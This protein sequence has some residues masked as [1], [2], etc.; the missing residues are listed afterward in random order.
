MR[1]YNK[2]GNGLQ[3][4][5]A[6]EGKM[7]TYNLPNGSTADIPDEIAEKWLKI[8]GVEKYIAPAD[9]DKAAKE[10][11]VKADAEKAALQEEN[12]RLLA[13]IE[14]LKGVKAV[15]EDK[16]VIEKTLDELKAE[17]DALGIEYA[18]NIGAAKLL[19]KINK[20]KEQK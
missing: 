9:L 1:L 17:A 16:G 11:K 14:K 13:E 15:E 18:P 3:H 7:Y 10:A 19:G 6:K 8:N 12:A 2:S 5:L 4:V 20:V